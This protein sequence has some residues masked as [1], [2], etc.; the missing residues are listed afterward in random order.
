MSWVDVAWAVGTFAGAWVVIRGM[1]AIAA[2]MG[3]RSRDE[4]G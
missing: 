2:W 3:D 4:L 1:V